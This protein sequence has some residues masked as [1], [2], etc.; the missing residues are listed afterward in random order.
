MHLLVAQQYSKLWFLLDHPRFYSMRTPLNMGIFSPVTNEQKSDGFFHLI[1]WNIKL[2]TFL[3][4]ITKDQKKL[5]WKLDFE[6]KKR[7][8]GREGRERQRGDLPYFQYSSF[9]CPYHHH[10]FQNTLGM[11]QT[12]AARWELC[13]LHIL[14]Q[15]SVHSCRNPEV[16]A[17]R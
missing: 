14:L 10:V 9:P 7:E 16:K 15:S 13:T 6:L 4:S 3:I 2:N 12:K 5:H 1:N 11:S 8:R 17:P